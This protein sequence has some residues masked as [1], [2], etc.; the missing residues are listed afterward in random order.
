LSAP[1]R[2]RAEDLGIR[3]V[4]RDGLGRLKEHLREWI[5]AA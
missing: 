4:D 2:L 3:V 1:E 5:A